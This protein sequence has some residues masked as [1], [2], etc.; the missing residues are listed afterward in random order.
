MLIT[1]A[2]IHFFLIYYNICL[3]Y[4]ART[5][6]TIYLSLHFR[7]WFQEVLLS[8]TVATTLAYTENIN[9]SVIISLK[10]Q[11]VVLSRSPSNHQLNSKQLPSVLIPN[12]LYL[13]LF[14]A[15]LYW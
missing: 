15:K 4:Y 2:V 9:I 1:G 5:T 10:Q 13:M 14:S 3:K 11:K 12:S 6:H 8:H 7:N